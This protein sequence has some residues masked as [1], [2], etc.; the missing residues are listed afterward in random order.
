MLSP[1]VRLIETPGHTAQDITTL[2][3]TADG[4]VACTP[5]GRAQGGPA[6][7]APPTS[8]AAREPGPAPGTWPRHRRTRARPGVHAR[9]LDPALGSTWWP[10]PRRGTP[11]A[12]RSASRIR[13]SATAR[14]I[15]SRARFRLARRGR[16]GG[17]AAGPVPERLASFSRLIV[18]DKRGTG[19]SDPVASPPSMDERMD[20]IGA[21]MDAVGSR[22][23][24]DVRHLG[25]RHA[26]PAVRRR[27]SGAH[28]SAGAVRLVGPPAA[29]ARLSLRSV[30][31]AARGRGRAGWSGRGR[32]ASGGTAA[33]RARPTTR[34]TAR[35]WARYLRMAASPA[36]A[37]N[38][39]R[40]NMR[41]DIRDVLPTI[42][43]P[44]L[45]LHRTGDSWI[46]VGHARYLARAH[47]ERDVRRAAGIGSPTV[48][49]RRRRDRGR[50]RGL[51]DRPQEPAA[52]AD[53]H[54]RRRAEPARTRGGA[55]RVARRDGAAR[56]PT[57]SS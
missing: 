51:P 17:T 55:P 4:L 52:A 53:E 29:R 13:W 27:A 47:P 18:F 26:Q 46:D 35:W 22:P 31:G 15:W 6:T 48:A 36:M 1:N 40:M 2:V 9:R 19:M 10:G 39:I 16:V 50:D 8:G 23:R 20:D 5:L 14:S 54:R 42:N 24:R 32:R 45:I 33:S 49:R 12:V 11:R 38:V 37:Q 28:A 56:S 3:D 43:V 21:V 7:R 57:T 44:T 30:R 34:G 25:G 41:L